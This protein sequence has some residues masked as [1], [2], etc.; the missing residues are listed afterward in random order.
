LIVDAWSIFLLIADD[1]DVD[2]D[3]QSEE[4][5]DTNGLIWSCFV[6]FKI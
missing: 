2:D 3:E 5:K 4:A 6:F 1:D